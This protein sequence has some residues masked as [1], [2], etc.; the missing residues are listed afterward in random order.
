MIS[1][2]VLLD[3]NF[4]TKFMKMSTHLNFEIEKENNSSYDLCRDVFVT[5]KRV[6]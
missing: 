4:V 3:E 1:F 2:H 6:N 5:I